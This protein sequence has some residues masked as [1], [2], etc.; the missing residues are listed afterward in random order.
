MF[1]NIRNK[2]KIVVQDGINSITSTSTI[3]QNSRHCADK[4]D[5]VNYNAGCKLLEK[6]Q[7]DW[8]SM[9]KL[10]EVIY[11]Y[12]FYSKTNSSDLVLFIN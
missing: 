2:L 12:T 5:N 9:H 7:N 3:D 1:N 4:Y 11:F 8:E 6:Y 10:S